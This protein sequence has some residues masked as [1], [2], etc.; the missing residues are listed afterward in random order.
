MFHTYEE[1]ARHLLTTYKWNEEETE[2]LKNNF[3]AMMAKFNEIDDTSFN[4]LCDQYDSWVYGEI[5]RKKL[6]KLLKSYNIT[7]AELNIY[8]TR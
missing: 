7:E 1:E 2:I 5:S 4:Y 3:P 8:L 6:D